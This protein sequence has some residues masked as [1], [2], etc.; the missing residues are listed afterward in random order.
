MKSLVPVA[1]LGLTLAT[2]TCVGLADRQ[3]PPASSPAAPGQDSPPGRGGPPPQGRGGRGGRATFPAQQRELADPAVIERG[4]G[5]YSAT[6][7]AGHGG[8]RRAARHGRPT[9]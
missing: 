4:R 9:L 8:R 5:I 7:S 1:V 2:A 6:S 3:Q